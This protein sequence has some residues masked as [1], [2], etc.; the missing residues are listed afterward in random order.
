MV[1]IYN[2]V[3]R[4]GSES[5]AERTRIFR[6]RRRIDRRRED[7]EAK[8]YHRKMVV[9]LESIT[10]A[11]FIV[12]QQWHFTF[13]NAEAEHLWQR[14]REELVGRV[15]WEEFPGEV[16]SKFYKE[17]QKALINKKAAHFELF[18]G[19]AGKWFEVHAYP[20]IEGLSIYF[21]D[22]SKRKEAEEVLKAERRRL[23]M[24]L[25]GLPA[26]VSLLAPNFTIRFANRNYKEFFGIPGR[27]RC[28]ELQYGYTEPCKECRAKEVFSD[29]Q[30]RNWEKNSN[31]TYFRYY[32]YP[33]SDIDG[34]PLVLNLG[35][36]I[37][38]QKR[39][40]KAMARLDRLNLIGEMAAG[41]GHEI[42]NPMTTVRGFLQMLGQKKDCSRYKEY[43]NL[44]IEEID[45][46]NTI[47]T[48]FLS[49]AKNKVIDLKKQN[50]NTIIEAISPLITADAIVNDKYVKVELGE[51]P[52]LL[53]DEKEIRQL[54]L[55]LA[56][57]GLEAMMPGQYL[58]IKTFT[59]EGQVI[60]AVQDQGEGIEP[61]FYD[62]I[63]TPFF[64]TKE[65]GT[66]LGLAICYSIAAR[67]NAVIDF[68]TGQNGT[69]F[70]VR[71]KTD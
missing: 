18:S 7:R 27:K 65:K 61:E 9:I 2:H 63:G 45:R 67:H 1:G 35:I 62:K 24:L 14:K 49:L 22:I 47:I 5:L 16:N 15:I 37:T 56:R 68:E 6:E 41:I 55:N 10:D 12:N 59:G 25:N 69:A 46:A 38:E 71:F 42:R 58:N 3:N 32:C 53:L 48:E 26:V 36:E 20:S 28:Y 29:N 52:D 33:F 54:T 39:L 21:R 64:T 51:V 11:F 31:N 57:N 23:L 30:P 4:K 66:G 17:C 70:Y 19:T 40:E 34:S 13:L 44:M 50:L 60:L 8:K 43:F